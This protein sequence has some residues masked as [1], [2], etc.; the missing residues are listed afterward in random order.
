LNGTT[1]YVDVR[2]ENQGVTPT[3]NLTQD[4]HY[5]IAEKVA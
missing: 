2:L 4:R 1:D 5:F 3:A